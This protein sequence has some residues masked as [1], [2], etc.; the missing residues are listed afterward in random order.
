MIVTAAVMAMPLLT[1][2]LAEEAPPAQPATTLYNALGACTATDADFCE[3][4]CAPRNL[5]FLPCM[6]VGATN[7]AR[8][9]ERE[10]AAC[11]QACASR[12][13]S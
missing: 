10:I 12:R 7:M 5:V 8:C 9:R 13:C 2:A 3:T 4:S 1:L 11:L 6:A